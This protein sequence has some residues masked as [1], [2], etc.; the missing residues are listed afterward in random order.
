VSTKLLR[1]S[2]AGEQ[3]LKVCLDINFSL[4]FLTSL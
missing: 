2:A 1:F 4:I 3:I